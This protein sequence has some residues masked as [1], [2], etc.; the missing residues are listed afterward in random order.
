M[1]KM[2]RNLGA[3]LLVLTMV[4]ASRGLAQTRAKV[5]IEGAR[6]VPVVG[7]VI[8]K[9][10]ILV[11]DG[12][13]TAVG[14]DVK[15]PFDAKVIDA[16]GK[17]VFP[18]LVDPLQW[19]GLDVSNE[20]QDVTP[21]TEVYDSID[22]SDRYFEEALRGGYTT[23]HMSHAMNCVIG[24]LSRVV[25]P[26]GMTVD[27]MT[28]RAD[29]GLMIS[30]F[31][32]RNYDHAVQMAVL[33][34]TFTELD[35]YLDELAEKR[36]AE[37]QEKKGEKV[38]VG[39]DEARKLGR[40]LVRESD[41]DRRYL[42]LWRLKQGKIH[43][44]VWCNRAMDVGHAMSLAE[45]VGF[46]E[47]MTL[48]TGS[49]VF[50]NVAALKGLK[51]PV[52]LPSGSMVFTERD[53]ITLEEEDTFVASVYADKKIPFALSTTKEP[54]YDA[55][56]LVR[57][58]VA[59]QTALEAVTINGARAIGL[60]HMVGSIEV[61]KLANLVILTG[62]P[63]DAMTWVD[64]VLVN[65]VLVYERSKDKRLRELMLGVAETE[66]RRKAEKSEADKA[67][68]KPA[69]ENEKK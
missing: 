28:Q 29:C 42:N 63:L 53:R 52:I 14:A 6:I 23:L 67:E 12:R 48:V 54:L 43:A 11:E 41:L 36:Y 56:R 39:P 1:R 55:A 61:G 60:D 65:G 62:D 8:E 31:P 5:M 46:K 69:G 68:K 32:K 24:G 58:G 34:D 38:T 16:S 26:I 19:N 13:I 49:E 30:I 50:K 40:D 57:N 9:G 51:R 20:S 35:R 22:P 44:F 2:M 21:F 59:R 47:N 25:H 33:R 66:E 64:G 17:T 4:A 27:E 15:A 7:E 10:N 18:G 37:E 45:K 3:A